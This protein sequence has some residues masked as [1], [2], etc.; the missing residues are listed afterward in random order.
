MSGVPAG[1]SAPAIRLEGVGMEFRGAHGAVRALSGIDLTVAP[2]E[3]VCVLG[4]SG[5]GTA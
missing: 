2:G 5:C 1:A 3:L 4:P